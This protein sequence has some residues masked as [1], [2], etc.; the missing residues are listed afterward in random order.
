[1][2]IVM[3]DSTYNTTFGLK[4]YREIKM[5]AILIFCYSR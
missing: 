2:P 3:Q 4:D 5:A 1:M